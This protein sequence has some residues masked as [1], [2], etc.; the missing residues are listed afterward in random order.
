MGGKAA[1]SALLRVQAGQAAL[2]SA[3]HIACPIEEAKMSAP[4]IV[5]TEAS[6][7]WG[8]QEIRVL[9]ELLAM[10]ARGCRVALLATAGAP[11]AERATAAGIAV[12]E[13]PGFRD[14]NPAT[15]MRLWR[16][17]R[18]LR[19]TVVNVHS[20]DDSWTAAPLA[21]LLDVPLVLRT[22]H[23]LTTVSC[24]GLYR[25]PHAVVA[26]SEAIADG[27]VRQGLDRGRIS[28]IPTGNDE[29]RFR[30]S[31][32]KRQALR[33]RYQIREGELLVGN[34]G[35][36]RG[37]KGQHFIL[38]TLAALPQRYRAI[39]VGDGDL[40][41]GLEQRAAELNLGGRVIFAGHQERPEDFYQAFDLFFFSSHA[42]EGVSQALVQALLNG[43]PVLACRLASTEEALAGV[44]A[45]KLVNHGDVRAACA[46][47]LELAPRPGR[48]PVQMAAQHQLIA[49][50]YGLS[51]MM[52]RLTRLYARHGIVLPQ[53][54]SGPATKKVV[55][56]LCTGA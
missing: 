47:V 20:S 10:R 40:R 22:R 28:V 2:C 8:G 6:R 37:Y 45:S 19:P 17:L 9:T 54:A 44:T 16:L 1:F 12:H 11:L 39:L 15:W 52:T 25:L 13:L 34:V 23:V 31:A 50:R 4:F 30:F 33:A 38:D 35:F 24:L 56:A 51:A 49:A 55:E 32:D 3:Q 27:L 53:A 5:H 18:W 42:A 7:S 43:L 29:G 41:G 14:M 21:R 46:G 48:D 26:C 36:L